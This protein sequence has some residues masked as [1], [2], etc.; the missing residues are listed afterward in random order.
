MS[1]LAA[2]LYNRLAR[3]EFDGLSDYDAA[4][5]A[6]EA[7]S[8]RL[9]TH[10]Q[11]LEP[12]L[13]D[14]WL[15]TRMGMVFI[16]YWRDEP[17][18]MPALL[19]EVRPVLE[20]EG[21][22]RQKQARY[23]SLRFAWQLAERRHRVDEQVLA[24]ARQALS[25]AEESGDYVQHSAAVMDIGFCLLFSGDLDGAE[26][27][28][29]DALRMAERS[30]EAIRLALCACFLNLAALRRHDPAAVDVLAPRAMEAAY[31]ASRPQYAA[32]AKAS[33]AWLAWKTGRISEVE[34]LAREALASWPANSWQPFHWVCL[35]PLVAAR[36]AA[37]QVAGAI[38]AARRLLP[39][40]QQ[41]LPDDLETQV[42]AAI[43]VWE[44]GEPERAGETLA[45]ALELAQELRYA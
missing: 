27:W 34:G 30:G 33:L 20:I 25:A 42:L 16:H 37:G 28:L 10:P 18:Q 24:E 43:E 38:D 7:A 6:F 5:T 32:T 13:L 22:R 35:W 44:G 21:V 11:H 36:L 14:L 31:A 41:R 4:L 17:D 23:H 40:P 3:V 26:E 45:V 1:I 2:R 29:T 12:G 9:G 15:D 19:A 39:A 8:E